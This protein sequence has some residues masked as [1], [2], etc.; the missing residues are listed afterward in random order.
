MCFLDCYGW[1][2]SEYVGLPE[3]TRRIGDL[4]SFGILDEEGLSKALFMNGR[5]HLMRI[6][7]GENALNAQRLKRLEEIWNAEQ[8]ALV[9]AR[10]R[11]ASGGKVAVASLGQGSEERVA[12]TTHGTS[13]S[14]RLISTEKDAAHALAHLVNASIPLAQLLRDGRIEG[15]MLLRKLAGSGQGVFI[16][17]NLLT[18][19]CSEKMREMQDA[20]QQQPATSSIRRTR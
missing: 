20:E 6:V 1:T 10:K 13:T 9:A 15:R 4:I 2:P 16:L 12:S 17:N 19:L 11:V 3:A 8:L 18:G 14:S 7:R 5:I